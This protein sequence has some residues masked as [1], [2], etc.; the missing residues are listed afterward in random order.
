MNIRVPR[1]V[2]FCSNYLFEGHFIDTE[3]YYDCL[4]ASEATFKKVE[5]SIP[6]N[7]TVT[8]HIKIHTRMYIRSGYLYL[9]KTSATCMKSNGDA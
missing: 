5:N 9:F 3:Q 1:L 8:T 4:G 2:M 6:L 7:Q